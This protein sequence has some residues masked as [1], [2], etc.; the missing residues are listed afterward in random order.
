M[1]LRKNNEIEA[2]NE[3]HQGKLNQ[4]EEV[5]EAA[6]PR[7]AARL[8]TSSSVPSHAG[9][10]SGLAGGALRYQVANHEEAGGPNSLKELAGSLPRHRRSWGAPEETPKHFFLIFIPY[11]PASLTLDRGS[12]AQWG[13]KGLCE[14][15][16]NPS[17]P[18]L[19]V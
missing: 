10:C 11:W 7:G 9:G 15:Y 18:P 1:R 4:P 16:L 17:F 2:E 14:L 5:P 13:E 12:V 3:R 8:I 6:R 19:V